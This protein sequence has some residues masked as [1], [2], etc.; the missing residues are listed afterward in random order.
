MLKTALRALDD[1]EQWASQ[2][3]LITL[4]INNQVADTNSY[5]P[6]Q[7]TFGKICRVPGVLITDDGSDEIDDNSLQIFCELMAHHRRHARPLN[8]ANCQMDHNLSNSK[9]VWVRKEG[10]KPSLAPVYEGPYLVIQRHDKY[11]VIVSWEG[12]KKV[13][14]DRLKTA[15]ISENPDDIGITALPDDFE[16]TNVNDNP[17]QLRRSNRVT[18]K[19]DR[20]GL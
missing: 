11:F 3:P 9:Y 5:T 2:I 7:K 19:P 15:Y 8:S 20:L 4:M 1:K 17:V 12:E 16:C 13:S 18:K 6:F 10:F 14:V